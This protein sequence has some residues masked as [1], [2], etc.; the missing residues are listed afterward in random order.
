MARSAC[1]SWQTALVPSGQTLKQLR[2]EASG[3]TGGFADAQFKIKVPRSGLEINVPTSTLGA[4]E[5]AG[6]NKIF[7]CRRGECGLCLLPIP[8]GV[9]TSAEP[10]SGFGKL[11]LS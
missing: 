4:L 11:V 3:N 7:G 2:Y 6:V 5:N 8:G 10:S 9:P 1:W